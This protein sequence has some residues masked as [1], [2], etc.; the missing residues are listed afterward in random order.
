MKKKKKIKTELLC[1][2][3]VHQ[4][5]SQVLP[6]LFFDVEKWKGKWFALLCF[7][8]HYSSLACELVV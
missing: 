1:P 8:T 7:A 2:F 3:S 4:R 6:K 5:L